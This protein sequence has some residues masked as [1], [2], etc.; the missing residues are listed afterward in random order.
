MASNLSNRNMQGQASNN[1]QMSK[2]DM[3]MMAV[4]PEI[5]IPAQIIQAKEEDAKLRALRDGGRS[6]GG[7]GS[8]SGSSDSGGLIL[9]FWL[10]AF[11]QL[12]DI[13]LGTQRPGFILSAYTVLII[14]SIIFV[15]KSDKTNEIGLVIAAAAAYF[16]PWLA[17]ASFIVNAASSN[18]LALLIQGLII[19][20]PV[21][22]LYIAF[23]FP[24]H[25]KIRLWAQ[26][27]I[28]FW[29]IVFALFM[30]VTFMPN[31]NSKSLINNPMAGVKY[32]L[33]GV[34]NTF[35]A[36][37]KTFGN[38]W[39]KAIAQAT[40]QPYDGQEESQVGIY[41]EDVRTL[42]SRYSDISDV[43][44]TAKIKAVNVKEAINVHLSCYIDGDAKGY[45]GKP[46]M[47]PTVLTEVVGNYENVVECRL[48]KLKDGS[49]TVKVRA[50]FDF[51]S[52]SDIT[53][54]FVSTDI[55]TDQYQQ[56]NINPQTIATYTG[57]P[58][59]LGLPSLTQ[60][61]RIDPKADA[62][63]ASSYPFGVSLVNKWSQGKVV[64][65][66]NYTLDTPSEVKLDGCSRTPIPSETHEPYGDTGRNK[67]FFNMSTTNAQ[68][69]FDAVRCQMKF[70]DIGQVLG[71]D[72][73]SVKTFAAIANYEYSIE[74]STYVLVEKS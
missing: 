58:V 22:P 13:I 50:T 23:K 16:L 62:T 10:A 73:K 72:L 34:G 55:K 54:T 45:T 25:S 35:T 15:F 52:T 47:N 60:P 44:V 3:A 24:D 29:I 33:S 27:V 1:R 51:E 14:I 42:E 69:A 46:A 65:G 67:Y 6:I 21:V 12:F 17:K 19:L 30:L 20:I 32:V 74:G 61:L 26:W 66:L 53:Y 9:I 5:A 56:L 8:G 18:N 28:T 68:E 70:T 57:G 31:Q 38:A 37:G 36:T 63:Q 2:K 11:I 59:E 41:V 71:S 4:A 40:G 39:N 7:S 43:I 64:R 49:Y 48:G